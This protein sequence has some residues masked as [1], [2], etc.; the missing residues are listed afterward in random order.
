[1]SKNRWDKL[2][3]KYAKDPGITSEEVKKFL[4]MNFVN[5]YHDQLAGKKEEKRTNPAL[6]M[7]LRHDL[8]S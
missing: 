7:D 4:E 2:T 1:M 5:E 6:I 8:V 3:S